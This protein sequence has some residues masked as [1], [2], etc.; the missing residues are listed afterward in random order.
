MRIRKQNVP[1]D[2]PLQR[3]DAWGT[4]LD[5]NNVFEHQLLRAA[6]QIARR[7]FQEQMLWGLSFSEQLSEGTFSLPSAAAL[8]HGFGE[9]FSCITCFWGYN[10]IGE[11]RLV[12]FFEGQLIGSTVCVQNRRWK[13]RSFGEKLQCPFWG[14][15][16]TLE[17]FPDWLCA[18]RLANSFWH[19]FV[20]KRR[21]EILRSNSFK[22]P[23]LCLRWALNNILGKQLV[24]LGDAIF[25]G[26]ISELIT[27]VQSHFWCKTLHKANNFWGGEHLLRATGGRIFD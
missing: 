14:Q 11:Q 16:S 21:E 2:D 12:A 10:N 9:L 22:E 6:V 20:V 13:A 17:R 18:F 26:T 19:M 4:R 24:Q 7:I 23:Q 15:F 1:G 3:D 8:Q 25:L 5:I 27:R